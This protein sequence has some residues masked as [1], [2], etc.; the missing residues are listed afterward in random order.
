M[1]Q[2]LELMSN[3]VRNEYEE[4]LKQKARERSKLY[5]Q[6]NK[7]SVKERV[8]KCR[9]NNK[10]KYEET[11]KKYYENNREN[12][13]LKRKDYQKNNRAKLQEKQGMKILCECGCHIRKDGLIDHLK[14]KKHNKLM[15]VKNE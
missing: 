6:N 8:N 12:I 7:Q 5:Y 14:T 10:E 3:I 4:M 9:E 11:D 2:T 1:E 13:L 15:E